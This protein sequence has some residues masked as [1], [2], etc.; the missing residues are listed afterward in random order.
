VTP[1]ALADLV[2]TAAHDVLA[3]RGLHR[4]VLPETVTVERPRRHEHGDYATAVA[5]HT[6]GVAPREFAGWLAGA[7]RA[8]DAVSSVEV[9]GPGFVNLWL[10]TGAQAAIV[11]EVLAAGEGYGLAGAPPR[12]EPQRGTVRTRDGTVATTGELVEAL[13]AYAARYALIRGTRI[14]VERWARRTDDNPLF[15]VQYAHSR[16]ASIARNAREL[17]VTAEP[18]PL[19]GERE[20]ELIRMLGEFGDV[21]TAATRRREP[22]RVARYLERLADTS[23][24]LSGV[25]PM[26][27][28][29][30][31]QRH[32]AR[33]ALCHATRQVL[34]NGLRL[35]GIGA[36]ERM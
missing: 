36:P 30:P 35:L 22:Q 31:A 26:G 14:D 24:E 5:L 6:S 23:H 32:A 9:A 3:D 17:G 28:E 1:T 27:D 29:Q 10:T 33:F 8:A 2:R 4:A 21:V 7:L 12:V 18:G 34:A 15:V 19:R 11:D 20:H 16:L 13:G 25:L